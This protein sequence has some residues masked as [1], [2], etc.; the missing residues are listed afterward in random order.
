[1][2]SC[3]WELE[4][5]PHI[6]FYHVYHLAFCRAQGRYLTSDWFV[7]PSLF[8]FMNNA[9]VKPEH[10]STLIRNYSRACAEGKPPCLAYI[11]VCCMHSFILSLHMSRLPTECQESGTWWWGTRH[12]RLLASVGFNHWFAW[13]ICSF[14]KETI[15]DSEYIEIS[16]T[17]K[18]GWHANSNVHLIMFTCHPARSRALDNLWRL[19]PLLYRK[20]SCEETTSF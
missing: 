2:S 8:C 12:P 15:N 4:S 1:M 9:R 7:N 11:S 16:I 5:G 17:W 3:L 18:A 13:S 20:Q 14:E 6:R 10:P 19:F